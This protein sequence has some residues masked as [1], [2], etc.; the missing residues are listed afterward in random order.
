MSGVAERRIERF[1]IVAGIGVVYC[2]YAV[3]ACGIEAMV[4]STVAVVIG[5]CIHAVRKGWLAYRAQRLQQSI[6]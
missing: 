6:D 4:G 2:A 3:Y 5:M 1:Y